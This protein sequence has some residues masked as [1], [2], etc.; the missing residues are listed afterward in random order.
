MNLRRIAR[1]TGFPGTGVLVLALVAAVAFGLGRSSVSIG[2]ARAQAPTTGYDIGVAG[3]P[4]PTGQVRNVELVATETSW[5]ISPGVVVPAIAYNGQVPGPTIRVMEG[6]TLRVT[7]KN[8]LS[9]STSIH[10]HGLH[11]P[12]AVDGVPG[13]TQPPIEPGQS[14][15]Y[16]F[17]ASHAGTFMYHPHNNSVEQI[18]RGLYA[19]LIIDPATPTT[20]RF[21]REYT[22]M[23]SAWDTNALLGSAD[24]M[25]GMSMAYNYF[26]INGKAFPSIEPWTVREGDLV[27]VRIINISNLAHPMHLHGGDFTVIAKDGEP[28]RPELQQ[29]MNTLS[30][31]AGETYDIAFRA[32]NPGT[33]VFHCH[34]LHHVENNGVEPGGLIQ[35]IQYEGL[36]APAAAT[37]APVAPEPTMPANMPGMRH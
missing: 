11:V 5:E 19:P 8:Q 18:D 33:W 37:V 22:M 24:N 30:V 4:A 16:E 34:E 17:Q 3:K 23:L 21:D 36:A 29:T 25:P 15:T 7:L 10:W 31:D 35:L 32:D 20:T 2:A 1:G 27:R 28:I 6:D 12:N 13:V 14:Y 9:Q 26:T